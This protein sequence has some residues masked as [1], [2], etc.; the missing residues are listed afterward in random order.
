MAGGIVELLGSGARAVLDYALPPRCPGCGVI[1]T[2]EGSFCASCWGGMRFLADPCCVR[3]G[4]PF[5]FEEVDEPL[6]GACLADPPPWT[7]ARAALAYCPVS[8]HIAIR[9]KYARRTVL[10][11]L[12]ARHMA[13]RIS[14]ALLAV[15]D[16]VV[17]IPVPLHRWR[18]WGRGFNQAALLASEISRITG[19]AHDPL[20]L[21]RAH[22]TR[23]LKALGP[24]EREREVRRAFAVPDRQRDALRGKIIVLIDDVHTSGATARACTRTLLEAGAVEVHLLCWARVL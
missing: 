23:P 8:S 24:R 4:L 15:R 10:S 2:A 12:M 7:S 17:L 6:C 11:R 22:A 19:L 3:C 16:Q 18:L 20:L 21:R 13:G 14:P 5:E 1:V 9:L